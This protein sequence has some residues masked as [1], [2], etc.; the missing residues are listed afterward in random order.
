MLVP[1][2]MEQMVLSLGFQNSWEEEG[3]FLEFVH[4]HLM[5]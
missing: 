4:L 1:V 2:K 3:A 5:D